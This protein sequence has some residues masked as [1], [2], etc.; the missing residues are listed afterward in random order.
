MTLKSLRLLALVI[1][2]A[3][4]FGITKGEA[5]TSTVAS[6][7]QAPTG[8]APGAIEE[9]ETIWSPFRYINVAG[10]TLVPR[11]S[12]TDWTYPGAGCIS[13]S[14]ANDVFN[15]HLGV[16][17]GSRIDYLRIYYYD[18]SSSNSTAWV[19]TYNGAGA[20]TD[21]TSV[22]SVGNSG[23]GTQ[24]G[25]YVGHVV[26][27][28]NNSYVLNWRSNQT[29]STMRLCGLRVAYRIPLDNIAYLPL[30]NRN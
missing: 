18:T 27:T 16:P 19:T 25:P 10:A 22:S 29:G 14:G 23:Y 13:A 21:R 26:D 9:V 11:A 4:T 17:N 15:I 3:A 12:A 30:V 1:L 5:T 20:T 6:S 7:A 28:A 8:A 2:L 24:L